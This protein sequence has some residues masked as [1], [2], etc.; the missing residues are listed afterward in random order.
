[1]LRKDLFQEM[2]GFDE[3]LPVAFNDI[4]L[5]LRL[6]EKGYLIIYTP[7]SVL[8]HYEGGTRGFGHPSEDETSMLSRW[9]DVI[10]KGDPYYNRNL[11]LMQENFSLPPRPSAGIPLPLA[12]L[13]EIY[14]VRVDLQR[15][16]PEAANAKYEKLIDWAVEYGLTVDSYRWICRPYCKW[17]VS[18]ASQALK[19][20]AI[21]LELYNFSV[22]LQAQFP[23][24]LKHDFTRL[25]SW[26]YE[27]TA[28]GSKDIDVDKERL[29][30]YRDYYKS[31]LNP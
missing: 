9:S 16:F 27:V 11:T 29:L 1:M 14:Y 28:D 15:R 10:S 5:C 7:F 21:L 6:R 23:E 24:V 19:P 2:G 17:Y 18:N 3:S 13:L 12:V 20:L 8:Y 26:A 31:G 22:K 4:D 30:P 25:L